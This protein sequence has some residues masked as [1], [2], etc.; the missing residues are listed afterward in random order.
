MAQ[1]KIDATKSTKTYLT[2][3]IAPQNMVYQ[4]QFSQKFY[5]DASKYDVLISFAPEAVYAENPIKEHYMGLFKIRAKWVKT[6]TAD[7]LKNV[8]LVAKDKTESGKTVTNWLNEVV[9]DGKWYNRSAFTI[10]DF[11]VTFFGLAV[12]AGGLAAIII[13]ASLICCFI[14][15]RKR[16]A[17]ADGARR[18]SSAVRR[19]S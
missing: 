5:I 10:G 15:Y 18:A 16:H 4:S 6:A 17:I 13:V 2:D 7:Q 8:A 9:P 1:P 14:S 11:E 19:G 3:E 12:G